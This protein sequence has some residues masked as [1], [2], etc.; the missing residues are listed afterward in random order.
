MPRGLSETSR[1][2]HACAERDVSCWRHVTRRHVTRRDALTRMFHSSVTD[3]GYDHHGDSQHHVQLNGASLPHVI[4]SSVTPPTHC[5]DHSHTHTHIYI[6]THTRIY[7]YT[8][9]PLSDDMEGGGDGGRERN[10]ESCV[11]IL[12]QANCSFG[13]F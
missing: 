9:T 4:L 11:H 8:H 12:L 13:E 10:E 1:F 7:I 5:H 3:G 2:P 6:Y